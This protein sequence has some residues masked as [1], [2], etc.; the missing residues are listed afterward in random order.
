MES[1]RLYDTVHLEGLRCTG[2]SHGG[3]QAQCFLFW[4]EAWLKRVKEGDANSRPSPSIIEPVPAPSSSS[5]CNR[6]RLNEL[7][8]DPDSSLTEIAAELHRVEGLRPRLEEAR[9]LLADLE[10]H[11]RELRTSWL[12]R[13]TE[14]RLTR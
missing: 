8:E 2:Q 1:R 11:A 13:Q 14:D 12:L 4:K 7:T 10:T 5:G 9:S 6:A 3:C